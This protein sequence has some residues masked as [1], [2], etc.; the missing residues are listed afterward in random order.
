MLRSILAIWST[1]TWLRSRAVYTSLKPSVLRLTPPRGAYALICAV[2]IQIFWP[3]PLLRKS[4]MKVVRKAALVILGESV[5][6]GK[7]KFSRLLR[8]SLDVQLGTKNP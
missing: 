8:G 5:V 4:A 6:V 3:P 2:E 1:S 7:H